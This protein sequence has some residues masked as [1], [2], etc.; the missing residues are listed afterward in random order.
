[1]CSFAQANSHIHRLSVYTAQL[2]SFFYVAERKNPNMIYCGA[3]P[4]WCPDIDTDL[5]TTD[6]W[7]IVDCSAA[8]CES[9]DGSVCWNLYRS[10]I[11]SS[12]WTLINLFGEFPLIDQH[13]FWGKILGTFTAVF[14]VA[15]FAL[16]VGVLAS[17]F[18]DQI[19]KRREQKALESTT[20]DEVV[21]EDDIVGDE[22]TLRGRLWNLF[23]SDRTPR[24]KLR[25]TLINSL[26]IGCAVSF[27]FDSVAE[28]NGWFHVLLSWFQ[29]LSFVVFSVEYS[30]RMYSAGEDPRYRSTRGLGHFSL[31]FLQVIDVLSILPYWIGLVTISGPGPSL[32]LLLKIFHVGSTNK[33]FSTFGNVIN[34][35]KDVLA[36]TGF[37]AMLLWIFFASIL[38]FTERDNPDEEMKT[39]YNTIPNA[40]WITLLNLSG[41]CPLAHYSNIGKVL[42]GIIGLFATAVFGIPIGILGAGFEELVTSKYEDTP[43]DED[44]IAGTPTI[45]R[46]AG[47]QM[48][49]YQFVNGIG[50][51]AATVFE[52][53]IY[54][55][56][57]ATVTIGI[58]QT[59]P[60][61]EHVGEGIEWL[62]VII[63]TVEY[64]IRFIG[65]GVDPEFVNTGSNGFTTRLKYVFS[66]YSIIDLMAIVP[67][68][69]AYVLPSSWIDAHDEYF[70]MMRILRLL[71]LDKYVPSISLVDDVVRLKKKILLVAGYAAATL[72]FL[73]SAAMFVTERSDDAIEVDPLPLYGCVENCYMSDRYR[74]F[75]SSVPLTGIHLTG[76]FPLVEY[77]GL[78]RCVLFFVVIAAVGVVSIPSGVIAAGFAEIVNGKTK[79]RSKIGMH[80]AGDDWFDI[81]YRKLEGQPPPLSKFGPD[82][83]VLQ[84][85]VKEYLDGKA[86]EISGKV[87]RTHFSKLG[88]TFF[89]SLIISNV[90]AVILES[91]PEIDR[92]V[93]NSAGNFFDIFEA[94]SVLCFTVGKSIRMLASKSY[95]ILTYRL[96]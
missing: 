23:H 93:G 24:A 41:E 69:I 81:K 80:A 21:V 6:E 2:S 40:M 36:V 83:D 44:G 35:H 82:I 79:S 10:I 1:M 38:Y 67:F 54:C 61:L 68:Y 95:T 17:G 48:A 45:Q 12:F 37:S 18:E 77:G 8:G 7:G 60:G 33:A 89:F 16:P 15:V 72:L 73:F 57:G 75:F 30:L 66:F 11:D 94:L 96:T 28:K 78:G 64:V 53:S 27:I 19:A 51:K 92:A 22:S 52:L 49:C 34:E 91:I 62:A 90:L 76:D 3:A 55:L 46:P 71:K 13:N 42:E 84:I 32:F 88:R 87:S 74:N 86:D 14:A 9:K 63:F 70:R 43:D 58:L 50:S 59:V 39:Y 26:I 65:A 85:K 56:I 4:D 29:F 47:L 20:E 25:K 31:K 5:C